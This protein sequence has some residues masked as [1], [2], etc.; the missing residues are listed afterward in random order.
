MVHGAAA[1][2]VAYYAVRAGIGA[3]AGAAGAVAAELQGDGLQVEDW[4]EI[5]IGAGL[6][7]AAGLAF[8]WAGKAFP[9]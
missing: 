5:A 2:V 6:G 8:G 9:G 3:A 1:P 7:A 4:D